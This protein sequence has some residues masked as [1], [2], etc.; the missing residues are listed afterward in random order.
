MTYI[1]AF[2][3]TFKI[4]K[5]ADLRNATVAVDALYKADEIATSYLGDIDPKDNSTGFR[6]HALL[7]LLG[8][9]FEHAQAMIVSVSTG[10][11]ADRKLTQ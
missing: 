11:A 4:D 1:P 8:R 5:K 7:N 2:R 9:I 3:K 10:V 6:I